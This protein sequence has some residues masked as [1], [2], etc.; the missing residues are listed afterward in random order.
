MKVSIEMFSRWKKYCRLL[1]AE[2]K[3]AVEDVSSPVMA[4]NVAFKL[5]IPKEA[6][7]WGSPLARRFGG[8]RWCN[9]L[10]WLLFRGRK[11]RLKKGVDI[12][13]AY[14]IVRAR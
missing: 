3:M 10:L 4:W 12:I 14:G 11:K 5:D 8:R 6:Y 2:N 9:P 7:P 1:L 13:R